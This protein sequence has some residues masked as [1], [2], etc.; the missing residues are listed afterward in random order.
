MNHKDFEV[1][2]AFLVELGIEQSPVKWC[3][4]IP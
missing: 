3:P 4:T 1:G 2:T